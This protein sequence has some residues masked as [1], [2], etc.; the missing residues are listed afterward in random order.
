MRV[1][2]IVPMYDEE[3]IAQASIETIFSY[4]RQLPPIV[5]LLVVNDGSRDATVEIIGR[6]VAQISDNNQLQM[7]SHI[8]NKGYGAALRT[9]IKFAIDNNYDY[10]I[11]MDSDLTNHPKYL[12]TFYEKI[13][14]GWDYIKA[15]R[16]SKG[17]GVK[18]V[19]WNHRVIS[20]AG[21]FIAR[22]LYKLPL[23]DLTNGFRAVKVD[24]LKKIN[25]SEFGFAIIM[26]ELYQAKYLTNS[27]CEIPYVL[28]SR[29]EGEGKTLFSY[30]P[31]TCFQY[32]K[33]AIKSFLKK[34]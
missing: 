20:V 13:L 15:T 1:C 23:T 28:T 8:V 3:A 26:E 5:T 31:R 9:G 21:N 18:G 10:A 11:F 29:K 12:K 34:G 33:Y 14:E 19:P 4:T 32:L 2:V 25:L 16:Y 30:S 7:I 24:I 22:V 6:L 27:F 17:G